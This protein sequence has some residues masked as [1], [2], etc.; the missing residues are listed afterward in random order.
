M[1][2][3][4]YYRIILADDHILLREGLKRI[5]EEKPELKIVAEAEDGLE[6][7][8]LV[9]K[10]PPDMVILDIAMPNL[11]GIEAAREIKKIWPDVKILILTMHDDKEYLEKAISYGVEGYLLKRAAQQELFIAIDSLR[12]GNL[13]ISPFFF[14]QL[15]EN[16]AQNQRRGPKSL[17]NLLSLREREVLKLVGG[18]KSS[19]EIGDM[20]F[21]S[22]RTVEHHRSNLL[23]KLGLKK[24]A[25]LVRYAVRKRYI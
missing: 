23:R 9:R 3:K 25:D 14:Q 1:P 20:L 19:K 10:N 12:K 2:I 8:K 15:T 16:W 22:M 5:L 7:L 4:L 24:T 17:R 13:Y 21:I 6:L 11:R 18:G